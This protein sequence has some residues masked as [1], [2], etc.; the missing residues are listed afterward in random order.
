LRHLSC[1]L[2]ARLAP[3]RCDR[4]HPVLARCLASRSQ[5]RAQRIAKP[6][7]PLTYAAW[8]ARAVEI[9]GGRAG[10]MPECEWKRA[11][12]TGMTPDAAAALAE[13]YRTNMTAA[14][15]SRR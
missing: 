1:V 13:T 15:R 12:V 3:F 5:P 11:C 10:I 9:M 6:A 8:K 14:D 7:E 4:I 2:A